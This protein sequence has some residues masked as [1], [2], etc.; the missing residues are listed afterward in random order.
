MSPPRVDIQVYEGC[1]IGT[2]KVTKEERLQVPHHLLDICSPREA[3]S[4]ADYLALAK[5]SVRHSLL[6]GSVDRAVQ[7]A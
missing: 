4:A 1:D 7:E 3:L 6:L 5:Q 2:A